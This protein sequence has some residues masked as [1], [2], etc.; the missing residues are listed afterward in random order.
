[1]QVVSSRDNFR[2]IFNRSGKK[3]VRV[4]QEIVPLNAFT[5]RLAWHSLDGPQV[6]SFVQTTW[7]EMMAE[8]EPEN[9]L[10]EEKTYEI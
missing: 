6:P 3:N 10:E 2:R 9:E 8:C 5:C 1:M 4:I 7:P